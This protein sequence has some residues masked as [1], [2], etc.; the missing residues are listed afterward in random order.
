MRGEEWVV[1]LERAELTARGRSDLANHVDWVSKS[2]GDGLG[3]DVASFTAAGEPKHIEVKTTN[4]GPRAPFYLTR[5][6]LAVSGELSVGF[7]LYRVFEFAR[8]PHLFIVTGELSSQVHLEPL[9]YHARV[10]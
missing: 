9:L 3:Y 1:E 2:R 7:N 8:D 6:E 10:G 5:R 4:L